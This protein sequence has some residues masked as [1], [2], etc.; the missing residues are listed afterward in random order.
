M[1]I[2]LAKKFQRTQIKRVNYCRMYLNVLLISDIAT[3]NGT[4]I[5]PSMYKG[6]AP[7]VGGTKHQVKQARPNE[8]SWKQWRRLLNMIA[9][10]KSDHRLRVPL[11]R[12][13]HSWDKLRGK[14][15]FLYNATNDKLFRYTTLGYTQ[16]EKI[17]VDYDSTPNQDIID[18]AIPATKV[19][20]DV[21]DRG[22]AFTICAIS[23]P[24]HG[25][26]DRSGVGNG[27]PSNHGMTGMPAAIRPG[28]VS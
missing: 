15:P 9:Y 22:M 18:P 24:Y 13:L 17:T 8:T 12:W 20:V 11:G 25:S 27:S 21:V 2:I 6:K 23:S 4:A 19:P 3:A 10:S 14:W 28:N 1:D 5:D 26:G 7:I 16:H